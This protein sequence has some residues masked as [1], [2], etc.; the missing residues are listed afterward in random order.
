[1]LYLNRNYTLI[2]LQYPIFEAALTGECT[3]ASST[4]ELT[5]F[6]AERAWRIY[7]TIQKKD[8]NRLLSVRRA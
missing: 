8:A 6:K 7:R 4:Y 5:H 3:L 1:M 2:T